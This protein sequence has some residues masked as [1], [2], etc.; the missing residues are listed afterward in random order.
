MIAGRF[1]CGPQATS[2]AKVGLASFDFPTGHCLTEQ[3]QEARLT[4][5]SP[6]KRGFSAHDRVDR[7]LAADLPH[8]RRDYI[9]STL[10]RALTDPRLFDASANAYS[11]EILHAAKLSPFQLSTKHRMRKRLDSTSPRKHSERMIERLREEAAR[12]PGEGDG[13]PQGDAVHG[14][15]KEPCPSAARPFTHPLP[16]TKAN[17]CATVRRRQASPIARVAPAEGRLAA[18]LEEWERGSESRI[19]VAHL[20]AGRSGCCFH[21]DYYLTLWGARITETLVPYRAGRSYELEPR[22]QKAIDELGTH[23]PKIASRCSCSRRV[24]AV[25]WYRSGTR[26][27]AFSWWVR[28]LRAHA[29]RRPDRTSGTSCRFARSASPMRSRAHQVLALGYHAS[30]T[31]ISVVAALYA[32]CYASR[33]VIF[34]AACRLPLGCPSPRRRRALERNG[35]RRAL[36]ADR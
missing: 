29:G 32:L 36:P 4:R 10:K 7:L 8:S 31:L 5:P 20:V 18:P 9:G 1:K 11:D 2:L 30:L 35:I 33:R 24:A 34:I 14:K 26:Q 25:W 15:Y 22:F 13:V 19:L 27:P 3:V 28:R 21:L 6:A 17:Y 12:F 23:Q 16:A